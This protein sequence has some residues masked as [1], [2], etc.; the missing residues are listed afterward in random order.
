MTPLSVVQ[1]IEHDKSS[2]SAVENEVVLM[3]S[4]DHPNIVR[5]YHYVTYT[6]ASNASNTLAGGPATLGDTTTSSSSLNMVR[7]LKVADGSSSSNAA[8]AVVRSSSLPS[9]SNNL[10]ATAAVGQRKSFSTSRS[11]LAKQQQQHGEACES[12]HLGSASR[13]GRPSPLSV[14]G[15]QQQQDH[16][17]DRPGTPIGPSDN[18]QQQQQAQQLQQQQQGIGD[19]AIGAAAAGSSDQQQQQCQ[20]ETGAAVHPGNPLP[21]EA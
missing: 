9:S 2:A 17:P 4:F 6:L 12:E 10:P 8:Q 19:E 7:G 13:S 18:Q 5:A 1:V 3:L 15:Q 20:A 21:G 16:M 14:P 11:T